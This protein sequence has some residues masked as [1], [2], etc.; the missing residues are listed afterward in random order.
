MTPNYSKWVLWIGGR[1][2]L[3][4]FR[5]YIHSHSVIVR[6]RCRLWPIGPCITVVSDDLRD[7]AVATSYTWWRGCFRYPVL[8]AQSLSGTPLAIDDH[9]WHCIPSCP[10]TTLA[11]LNFRSATA[12]HCFSQVPTRAKLLPQHWSSYDTVFIIALHCPYRERSPVVG[13]GG[14]RIPSA[15]DP[16]PSSCTNVAV[17]WAS[18]NDF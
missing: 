10:G 5:L 3:F 2:F 8:S 4:A 9:R 12:A 13:K 14:P 16:P 6:T 17:L 15:W 11:L 18:L 7:I 1:E